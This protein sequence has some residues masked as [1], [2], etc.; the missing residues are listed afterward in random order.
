MKKIN[1]M[2]FS[3]TATT[4]TVVEEMGKILVGM[5][6]LERGITIDFTLPK[7]RESAQ[8]FQS[9][10]ILVIGVPVYAGR[11]PNV[12]LQY[13]NTIKGDNSLAIPIVLYG[14]RHYDDA[15]LELNDILTK[16]GFAVIAGGAFIGEHSFSYTLAKERPDSTDLAIVKEFAHKVYT[17]IESNHYTTAKVNGNRPYRP[18]YKPKNEEDKAVDIRKVDPKTDHTC[19]DCKICSEVCP[20]GSIPYNDVKAIEGIC[21][22]CGACI[23]LCPTQS[24][25]FDDPDYLRHKRELEEQFQ[26]RREPEVFV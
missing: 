4:K 3:P 1:L 20:M 2:Y 10:D 6:G 26:K 14:N 22:K 7:P 17:K 5:K 19:I 11:V 21:I 15:L 16:N 8:N 25:Y 13:I 9:N 24:K 23:K 12:L 18:Y